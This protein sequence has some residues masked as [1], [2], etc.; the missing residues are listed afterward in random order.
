MSLPFHHLVCG[1]ATMLAMLT[2]AS[3]ASDGRGAFHHSGRLKY[4]WRIA[5]AQSVT[6]DGVVFGIIERHS[7]GN[8]RAF[9]WMRMMDSHSSHCSSPR[10][11]APCTRRPMMVGSSSQRLAQWSGHFRDVAGW[12]WT[13]PDLRSN[14]GDRGDA[15]CVRSVHGSL[16][17][18]EPRH[19]A[20]QPSLTFG[21]LVCGVA[22]G[23]GSLGVYATLA[24]P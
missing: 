24:L 1:F 13:I 14:T 18:A 5:Y 12:E 23:L 9:R 8:P 6:N 4:P 21:L 15:W 7:G 11:G 16:G 3:M 20:C 17:H 10:D 19:T 2:S 22:A